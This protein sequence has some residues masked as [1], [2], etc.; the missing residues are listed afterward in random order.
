VRVPPTIHALLAAR[1]DQLEQHERAVLERGSVEGRL[2]HRGAVEALYPE[3]HEVTAR[4][5]ALVRKDL[6]RP[7]KAELPG[8]DAFRFRHL[9]IRDAAYD[10]LP[11]STR[12]R[13]H[14]RFARW[15]EEFGADLP[16][17][18]EILGYHLEQACRYRLELGQ[19]VDP[20]LALRARTRLA[21]AGRRAW[22]RGDTDAG[23]NLLGR[24]DELPG[25]PDLALRF[26]YVDALWW[27]GQSVRALEVG[28]RHLDHAR[29]SGDRAAEL[30]ARVGIEFVQGF[31]E[32]AG[33]YERMLAVTQA[34]T[35]E[36]EAA[37]SPP[38]MYVLHHGRAANANQRLDIPSVLAAFEAVAATA[39]ELG[40]ENKFIPQRANFRVLAEEP[41]SVTLDWFETEAAGYHANVDSEHAEVLAMLGRFDE[42]RALIADELRL[43]EA[44]GQQ[45][46]R[47]T[48]L[49]FTLT[50]VE[51]LAGDF[52]AAVA[53][54]Q[55][56]CRLLE[57]LGA[58]G[59]LS[60]TSG[61]LARARFY[62]ADP[63]GAER[64]ADRARELGADDDTYT[65]MLA[66]QVKGLVL[67]Q[68]GEAAEAE[69][70][71][72]ET[73]ALGETTHSPVLLGDAYFDLGTAMALAGERVKATEAFSRALTLFE[74]KENLVMAERTRHELDRLGG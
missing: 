31:H 47:G 7:D 65:V 39:R 17:I 73:I 28:Q 23:V 58:V 42:A 51:T 19:E 18:D 32:P 25:E 14:E 68:R 11:K 12:A 61:I 40:I 16:E 9:L 62:A 22:I 46:R 8:Q 24:A 20:A 44:F 3:E 38:V 15:L 26:D 54:G 2:F 1:L 53:A 64:W 5:T 13:L 74:R 4:L 69:R 10:A 33:T 30:C 34:L 29:A 35:D 27:G 71:L 60:T 67:A 50:R 21:A 41:N 70:L 57:E 55:E 43:A 45:Q 37:G 6:V 49:G 36:F 66:N 52:D 56:G 59:L 63:D 72:R 48:T